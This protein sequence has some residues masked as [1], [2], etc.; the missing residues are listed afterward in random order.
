MNHEI[1]N[2]KGM[3]EGGEYGGSLFTVCTEGVFRLA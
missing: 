1:N 2:H 3:Y